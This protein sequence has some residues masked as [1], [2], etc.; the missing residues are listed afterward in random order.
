MHK[1]KES[2]SKKFDH[3]EL[4]GGRWEESSVYKGNSL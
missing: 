1:V 4:V 3:E 2:L